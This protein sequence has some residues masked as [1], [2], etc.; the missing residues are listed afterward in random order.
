MAT[1]EGT[2]KIAEK[3]ESAALQG[4]QTALSAYKT[5]NDA[6]FKGATEARINCLTSMV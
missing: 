1:A 6:I 3:V 5:A 2:V 4:A